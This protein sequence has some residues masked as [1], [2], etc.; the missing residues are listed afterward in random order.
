MRNRL[1]SAVV[2]FGS[3]TALMMAAQ[4]SAREYI[5]NALGVYVTPRGQ[6]Y[7]QKNLPEVMFRAGYSFDDGGFPKFDYPFDQALSLENLPPALVPYRATLQ[8]VYDAVHTYFSGYPFQ[9][10]LLDVAIKNIQYSAQFQTFGINVGKNS[11]KYGTTDGVVLIVNIV[12]PKVQ[13]QFEQVLLSDNANLVLK[14]ENVN[15]HLVP[16]KV[17]LQSGVNNLKAELKPESAPLA[18]QIPIQFRVDP[19]EG[20]LI[21]VLNIKTNLDQILPQVTYD[22]PLVLPHIRLFVEDQ[23]IVPDLK[24]LEQELAGNMN[25]L[26]QALQA[27]VNPYIQTEGVKL[28]NDVIEAHLKDGAEEIMGIAP[29][30]LEKSTAADEFQL[31]VRPQ[32]LELNPLGQIHFGLSAFVEDP[33]LAHSQSA[34]PAATAKLP[35]FDSYDP[36]QYDVAVSLNQEFVNRLLQLSF[37][38]GYFNKVPCDTVICRFVEAPRF[39]VDESLGKDRARL[40]LKIEKPISG[41]KVLAVKN[42]VQASMDMYVHFVRAANGT[43]SVV[44]DGADENSIQ[45]DEKFIRFDLLRGKVFT[46]AKQIIHDLSVGYQNKPMQLLN[47]IPIPEALFGIPIKIKDL[48]SEN[49]GNILLYLEYGAN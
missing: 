45:I 10:P 37:Q 16:K 29:P 48:Q 14:N 34:L 31:G 25:S 8:S 24:A 9:N 39:V 21:K 49:N 27:Q 38:R 23:E 30:G 36:T 46:G 6:K 28:A 44:M 47:S 2:V 19:R 3:L 15:G 40:H 5:G 35:V 18:I 42:P 22:V 12:V 20:I 7:F 17:P 41:I 43:F 32:D 33:K 26:L 4:A 1:R 13:V 11:K